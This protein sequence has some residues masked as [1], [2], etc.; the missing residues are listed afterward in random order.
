MKLKLTEALQKGIEAH[1]AGNAQ[2]AD[3]Y[4]T[5]ILKAN[6]KHPDANHNMGVLAVSL[7]KVEAALPFFKTALEVNSKINQYWLS[8]IDALIKL[9]R[10]DDARAVFYQAKNKGKKGDGFDQ[11]EQQLKV[12][13]ENYLSD[14]ESEQGPSEYQLQDLIKLYNK[15]QLQQMLTEASSLISQFPKSITLSFMMGAAYQGLGN[16]GVAVEFYQKAI[17]I[18]PDHVDAYNNMGIALKIQ[19][20]LE[21]AIEAFKKALSLQPDYAEV[22][23]NMGNALKEQGNLDD[24]IKAYIKAFSIKPDSAEACCYVGI[25]LISQGKLEEAIEALN[26]ALSIKPDY[27]DAHYNMGIALQAAGKLEEAVETYNKALTLKPDYAEV[28]CN[29][30]VVLQANGKMEEATEAFNKALIFNP[31]LHEAKRNIIQ[32]LKIYSPYRNKNPLILLDKK[33]K[34]KKIKMFLKDNNSQLAIDIIEIIKKIHGTDKSLRTESSQIFKQNEIDLNC[35]RHMSIFENRGIIPEF[36]FGCYKVQVEVSSVLDLIR[37]SSL[38]YTVPLANNNTRKCMIETR[39]NIKG[40][41]KGFIYCRGFTEALSVKESFDDK[42]REINENL[43]SKIKR[44]CSEFPLVFPKYNQIDESGI[45]KMKYPQKWK[46][47][48]AQF[49]DEFE[50]HSGPLFKSLSYFCL[51]DFL[52]LEKWID[53]AKGIGD[54]TSHLFSDLQIKY[55]DVFALA[56]DR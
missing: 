24:A 20:K 27:T 35:E 47:I 52:V 49:D 23:I 38:F 13:G 12:S 33:I 40:S 7:G 19:G 28:Y 54:P 16:L 55:H 11:L 5:V 45:S 36:C 18:K 31:N 46:S 32:L 15:G 26:K 10:V 22:Y 2:E 6:P 37:L 48:E 8:Y 3:R 14:N 4:Y 9:N 42:L 43:S 50:K 1:R 34:S 39:A 56:K 41:Y 25:A 30:G 29:M 44:G 21:E 51:S 53:Y 17:N